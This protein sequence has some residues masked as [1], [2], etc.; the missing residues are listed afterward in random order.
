[1]SAREPFS[2]VEIDVDGC[3]LTFGTGACTA[4]LGVDGVTRKC[5][6]TF[7]TCRKPAD[8][9]LMPVYRTMRYCQPRSNMPKGATFFPLLVG[10]PSE[11]SATVN[12][13]GSDGD[14]SAFGRRATI[15]ARFID[16]PDHD[17]YFDKYQLERV[18]G[19][20]Q[21]DGIGYPPVERGTHFAKLKTR[22]P[23]YAGRAMRR[24]D[25]YIENGA[26]V[27]VTTRHYVIT[28]MSGPGDDMMVTV[29]GSDVLDLADDKRTLVPKAR[30]GKLLAD[31]SADLLDTFSLS[32]EGVGAL[33]YPASGRARIGSEFVDYTRTGDTIT[34]T[35]RAVSQT[36]ASTHRSG[37]TFQRVLSYENARVD[38]VVSELLQEAGI[39]ASYLP[40]ADWAAEVNRWMAGTTLTR[41]IGEPTGVKALISQIVPL[42]FS[43]FWDSA[44]QK[45]RFKANRP[46]DGETIW[47]LSDLSTNLDID[48]EED[49]KKRVSEVLFWTVQK[50]P[51][52]SAT[53]TNNY[54]RTW[55]AS[56]PSAHEEWRYRTGAIKSYTCP[57][58]NRGADAIV[59]VAARR[60]L[61]RFDTTPIYATIT[62]DAKWKAI[63]LTDVVRLRTRGLQDD[64]G[65]EI[66]GLFQVTQ[67]SEPRAGE[68]IKIVVQ[69]YQFAGRFAYA[70]AN[71]VPTY[72]LA[73]AAQRDPGMFAAD[74][75]T[76]KMPNGDPPYEAI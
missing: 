5:F 7:N 45:I 15:S 71:D 43:L 22:W 23:F 35:A 1:M 51:A 44:A 8:Y 55:V 50:T 41:D 3:S 20:A 59:R 11:Y 30:N 37:D 14:L 13:A 62:L 42:G 9:D 12:I 73:T 24:H 56:D 31:V 69:S 29:E 68:R 72:M 70:T 46:V 65:R 18:S 25:G 67:R 75:I 76:L 33:E 53:D 38:D 49:D 47:D 27:D 36:V 32:P 63:Q 54:A 10:E 6:N 19:A 21:S 52:G 4:A 2:W 74:P 60:L 58:L 16:A 66:E 26:I 64:T 34:L 61:K 57:W 17:R 28:N 48:I 40:L 39:D